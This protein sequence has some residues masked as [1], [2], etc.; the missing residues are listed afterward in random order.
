VCRF[1]NVQ[2]VGAQPACGARGNDATILLE[3]PKGEFIL[4]QNQLLDQVSCSVQLFCHRPFTPWLY[5]LKK[6]FC[7]PS[8]AQRS[9]RISL[10]TGK[11]KQDLFIWDNN[12]L[13]S[14]S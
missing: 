14:K 7:P 12:K 3:N 5:W 8:L 11:K 9:T 4:T 1:V 13:K 6:R 10:S 2:L